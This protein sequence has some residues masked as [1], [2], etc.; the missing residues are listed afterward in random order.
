MDPTGKLFTGT[1]TYNDPM[2]GKSHTTK[3]IIRYADKDNHTMEMYDKGPDGKEF[4]M[5]EIVYKR[6]K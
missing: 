1:S 6:V 4:R 2:T 5:M 3:T